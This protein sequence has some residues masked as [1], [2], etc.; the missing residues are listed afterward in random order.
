M[1][2]VLR[3]NTEVRNV[4][5]VLCILT[6]VGFGIY[7]IYGN[8][9]KI[10]DYQLKM[11]TYGTSN[12]INIADMNIGMVKANSQWWPIKRN[13]GIGIPSLLVGGATMRNGKT[14]SV[15]YYKNPN[16]MLLIESNQKYYIIAKPNIG[17]L[18]SE[19]VRL[20]VHQVKFAE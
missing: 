14:A 20:G 8:G 16:K 13:K 5:T 7:P 19:L 11:N 2:R 1:F 3:K 12:V 10:N 6:T 17:A 18:Y 9:W 4:V 15:F